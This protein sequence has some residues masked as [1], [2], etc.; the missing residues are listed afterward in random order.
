MGRLSWLFGAQTWNKCCIINKLATPANTS[1]ANR[2]FGSRFT[3]GNRSVAATYKGTPPESG[4]AYFNC[5]CSE[6]VSTTPATVATP[7]N[8]AARIALRFPSPLASTTDATV[9]PSGTL[10]NNTPPTITA[11]THAETT[12]PPPTPTPPT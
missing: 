8:P 11:P 1:S 10:S 3:S 2:Q 12:N 6:L 7:N 5:P 4:S 9:K